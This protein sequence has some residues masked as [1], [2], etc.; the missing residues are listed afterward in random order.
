MEDESL[1]D[2]E[3]PAISSSVLTPDGIMVTSGDGTATTL[4][5]SLKKEL[6]ELPR[7]LSPILMELLLKVKKRVLHKD[8]DWV[9]LEANTKIR[10]PTRTIAIKDLIKTK[11]FKICAYNFQKDC[12]EE[13]DAKVFS[14]GEQVVYEIETIDG[15]KIK[16]TA[17]HIFFIKRNDKIVELQLKDLKEGDELVCVKSTSTIKSIKKIGIRTTY[18]LQVEPLHNFVLANNIV[19]HNCI[20]DGREGVGKSIFA[21][22]VGKFLDQN[23]NISRIVFNAD[24]FVEAIKNAKKFECVILDEA[25]AS[26]NARAAL[27]ET[28]RAL[29]AVATEMRQKN[30][31]VIICLPS[32]FDLDR[33]FAIWRA[34]SLFH[35]YFDKNYNRGKALFFPFTFKKNLYLWGKKVYSYSKPKSPFPPITFHNNYTV[36]EVEYR[37]KKAEAFQDRTT[38]GVGEKLLVRLQRDALL[39][40]ITLLVKDETK[41][42]QLFEKYNIPLP[43][44]VAG[45]IAN[46]HH[47]MKDKETQEQLD[48][49][50]GRYRTGAKYN[51]SRSSLL[52]DLLQEEKEV[53]DT[54]PPAENYK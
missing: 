33:Y 39:T 47:K 42:R 29:I 49:S 36:D 17:N 15:K 16:A 54:G 44:N 11:Q 6:G 21:Q 3:Q 10:L 38:M 40:E 7:G 1:K 26:I 5:Q 53:L 13:N 20:V 24:D 48:A 28:N 41:V 9:C 46:F 45:L 12:I 37:K 8:L 19:T 34:N 30:L 23:L 14:T 50:M 27:T 51:K 25:Y 4:T 31:F 52:P 22:Q 18:D 32:F 2:G 35:C 43:Q